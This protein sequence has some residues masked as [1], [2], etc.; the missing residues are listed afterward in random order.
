MKLVKSLKLRRDKMNQKTFVCVF[1]LCVAFIIFCWNPLFAEES[2]KDIAKAMWQE[3]KSIKPLAPMPKT[4][5]IK[6]NEFPIE[7]FYIDDDMY[8]YWVHI[9]DG[10]QNA[11]VKALARAHKNNQIDSF[12]REYIEL[13]GKEGSELDMR[14]AL[15]CP[16]L[17]SSSSAL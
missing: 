10:C 12:A 17:A 15:A 9:S 4:I 11:F 16:L 8:T 5:N 1:S 3:I 13:F 2:G 6:T 7:R 14:W